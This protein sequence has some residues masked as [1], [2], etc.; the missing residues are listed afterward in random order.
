MDDPKTLDDGSVK[1]GIDKEIAKG[2]KYTQTS[3]ELSA[4][5]IDASWEDAE[6]E[7]SELP[8]G[9]NETPDESNVD[10]IG[11]ALG[12]SYEESEPL[13]PTKKERQAD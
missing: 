13:D 9:G 3:P 2:E 1:E 10:E 5:D 8:G 7:G 11:K 12:E 6:T 4:G